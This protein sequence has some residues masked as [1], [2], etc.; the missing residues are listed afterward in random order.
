MILYSKL[1][2]RLNRTHP[3][4]QLFSR[5]LIPLL[6]AGQALLL[7]FVDPG[8]SSLLGTSAER[9]ASAHHQHSP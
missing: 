3:V 7:S 5:F 2:L 6:H 9:N 4:T 1:T 8:I